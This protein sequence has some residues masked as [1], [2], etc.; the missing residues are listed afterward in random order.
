MTPII[1]SRFFRGLIIFSLDAAM[2]MIACYGVLLLIESFNR[3]GSS[4][5]SS[6]LFVASLFLVIPS[7]AAFVFLIF[8]WKFSRP[9]TIKKNG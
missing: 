2:V 5:G 6:L 1:R 8:H 4:V 3:K 7:F 9:T